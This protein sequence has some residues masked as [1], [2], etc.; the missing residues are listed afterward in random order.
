MTAADTAATP[1]VHGTVLEDVPQ[2]TRSYSEALVNAAQN[3]GQVDEILDELDAIFNEVLGPDTEFAAVL[4]SP[5]VSPADKDRTLVSVFEGRVHP[6]VINFLRVL[7]RHG[8]FG[9]LGATVKAARALWDK[10]QNRRPV[11]V[12]TAVPLDDAQQDA[13]REHLGRM[14]SAT[15]LVQLEVDP[16]LIG[17]MVIQLDDDVYDASIRNRLE[18]LRQRLIEGKTHEIQ[19]RRNHF[20]DSE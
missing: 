4:A 15:P 10:R 18:Q 5:L 12:R 13:L 7:N 6:T 20:S 1:S 9:S 16:S 14:L 17:G 3:A 8:R 2:V 19:S 11:L